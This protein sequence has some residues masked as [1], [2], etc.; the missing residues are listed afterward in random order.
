MPEIAFGVLAHQDPE[1][2][3]RLA[4]ALAGHPVVLHVDATTDITPFRDIPGVRLVEDRVD[5]RWGGFSEVEAVLR[6]YRDCLEELG[7][8]PGSSIALLSGADFP[9]RP[10]EEFFAYAESVPWSEHV[11][12]IPVLDGTPYMENKVR[13]RHFYDAAPVGGSGFSAKRRGAT[14]RGLSTLL[15]RVKP[16]AFEP[17]VPVWGSTWTMLSRDCLLDILPQAHDPKVQALFRRTQT[18][19][20]M[21]FATLVHSHP[22]WS[23]RT[24]FGVEPR[25][26]KWP[27][28][29]PNFS[30][31]HPTLGVWL[32]G[33]YAEEI[34]E[35]GGYFAR[36]I[37]SS[38]LDE[39][40]AAVEQVRA[41]SPGPSAPRAQQA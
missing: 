12:A 35:S 21:Y 20:E 5:V 1:M 9:V 19:L 32:D 6:V 41:V 2:T 27:S 3:R 4:A 15:P 11:R 38:D 39:V 14:R 30:Y 40:L 13:R 10:L 37:R 28:E 36:K 29:F 22:T 23:T 24:E 8:A 33:S 26:G 31:I 7:D 17:L 25:D 16:S 18:P 34:V